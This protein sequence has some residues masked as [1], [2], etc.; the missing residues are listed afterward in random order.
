M[1][2]TINTMI[3]E[4]KTLIAG[5]WIG[6]FGWE[7][8]AWQGYIR[9]LAAMYDETVI[10]C[11]PTSLP[12]YKDFATHIISHAPS[13]GP[14]DQW[15]RNGYNLQT[16]LKK[17]LKEQASLL[18][19]KQSDLLLPKRIG[20]PNDGRTHYSEAVLVGRTKIVPNYIQ[21][22]TRTDK[23]Y[24]YVLHA[25]SRQIRRADNWDITRWERLADLL[26]RDNKKVCSIGMPS[27]ALH[28]PGT[29]DLR[30]MDTAQLINIIASADAVWGPSS[31]AMHL[32]SLCG[33]PHVVWSQ[34]SNRRRY[35]DSWNPLGTPV[36][37]LD[38]YKWHP[39]PEYIYEEY[40]QWDKLI[41][42]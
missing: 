27:E 20:I 15:F 39:E 1:D 16:N 33:A 28:V 25:R 19:G 36:L 11:R 5:P 4:N 10:I 32:A 34:Q 8:F 9:A 42:K 30:G 37:F 29:T 41:K 24:D 23:K 18:S 40:G 2:I 35:T 38:K 6:E 13:G 26:S 7:L 17:I 14:S 21:F 22:G 31:G 3:S 12:I